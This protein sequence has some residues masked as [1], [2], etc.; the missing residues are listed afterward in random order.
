VRAL[1]EFISQFRQ[2]GNCADV[3]VYDRGPAC[4]T[5]GAGAIAFLLVHTR[6][7]FLSPGLEHSIPEMFMISTNPYLA[8]GNNKLTPQNIFN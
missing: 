5:G 6:L 4:C 2:N 3:A 8:L 7:W 1:S